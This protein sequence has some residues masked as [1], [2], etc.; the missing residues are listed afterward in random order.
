MIALA[1]L[2]SP[3]AATGQI[4]QV[5]LPT[6]DLIYDPVTQRIYASVPSRAGAL[7][8]SVT[9]IDPVSGNIGPSVFVGS[10]PNRLA[11]SD[12]GQFLYVALDG[13]AAVRRLQL[14]SLTPGLQF[15]LGTDSFSGPFYV[16]DME[17]LPGNPRAIAV[18]RRNQGFSPRH[19]GVA[20]YDDGIQ[21]PTTT[22]DHTGSNRIEFSASA[23]RL[24]GLNN[25]TTEFG[26]RRMTVNASGVSVLSITNGL[27]S[28]FALEIK[29]DGGRIYA[30]SGQVIDPEA[31]TLL[32]RFSFEGFG[33]LVRPDTA[34]GRVYFLTQNSGANTL[35]VF[36]LTTFRPLQAFQLGC[37][38]A[39]A[40]SLIRWGQE[41][42]AFRTSDDQIFVMAA[43]PS[44]GSNPLVSY[45]AEGA[46]STFFETQL[47][48]FNP[49]PTCTASVT[50]R[51][52]KSDGTT[53]TSSE[54]LSPMERETV[55]TRFVSGLSTAEFSTTI[56]STFPIV[57][58][59]T[60]SWDSR[61]YGS[62]A[63]TAIGAPATTWYLAE[64]ATHSGF[65]LF[66]LIQNP[67]PSPANIQVTYLQPAPGVPL[68]KTYVVEA[69]SRFT[70]WVNQQ[71]IGDPALRVLASSDVSARIT[72][73]L[74]IVVERAMYLNSKGL[75]F[76]AG[77]ESAGVTAPATRWFLAEGATGDY[78]DLFILVANP[79]AQEAQVEATYLL[80]SGT[81][82]T[83]RYT[84]APNSRFN[85]WV[86]KEDPLL[87]DAAVS[88][89]IAS[90]NGVPIIV[91]RSMWWPGP[92]AASWHEAHNS[93]GS[94]VSG[95]KWALAGGEVGG[96]YAMETYILIANTS[97]AA[98]SVRVTLRFEDNTSSVART[99]AL[100]PNSRFNVDVK[101]LFPAA[102]G[103][104][105][106]ALVESLGV[107]PAQIVVERAM[108]SNS[109]GVVW[110]AGTNLL[111]TKIQ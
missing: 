58:D 43:L 80:Q 9:A 73:D 56:E 94:L 34:A 100:N 50:L 83:K 59:R 96:L 30:S 8:N 10:E 71:A 93:P 105:F 2:L 37:G 60:M 54:F 64:G 44:P 45:F 110:A 79:G 65:N 51:F 33:G 22:P 57:A 66:Y 41:G 63:E 47:A 4:R 87:V 88:T 101:A 24:Y 72:S 3:H 53:V 106:G 104:R 25:E 81:T 1:I 108:Y 29:F 111:A 90:T 84:V 17:V 20:I 39:N 78:F 85:I 70:I 77:H 7:G 49:H 19:E 31:G 6:N 40:S 62:H 69:S 16:E 15:P 99:F 36:D 82:L 103:K 46:T 35:R 13:A 109:D 75:A 32:G 92:T 14:P 5:A 91:E 18:S 61:R 21:R 68:T 27:I 23:A 26:F 48:L 67:N 28:G 98:G 11:L 76:G 74:P 55:E 107:T 42:L 95:V 97:A 52:L 38:S 89:T 12:D 102:V 86:D